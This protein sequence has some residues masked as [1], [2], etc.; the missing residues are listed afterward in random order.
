MNNNGKYYKWILGVVL[1]I[2][3]GFF[4]YLLNAYSRT[5]AKV[6][7]YQL[8]VKEYQG[9]FSDLKTDIAT[10]KV[11]LVWIKTALINLQQNK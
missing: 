5:E 9:I 10:I 2:I 3:G 6:A 7:E 8:E 1:L 4:A 11:D